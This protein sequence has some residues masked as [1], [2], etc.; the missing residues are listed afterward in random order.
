MLPKFVKNG[1]WH[2]P[3]L[4]QARG[5]ARLGDPKAIDPA[6]EKQLPDLVKA[7]W[8]RKFEPN[9]VQ[10]TTALRRYTWQDLKDRQKVLEKETELVGRMHAAGVGLLAGSD[11][12]SPLVLAGESIHDELELFVK[13]GLSPADALRTATL[14]PAKCLK[15]EKDLGAIEAGRYADLVLLERN[16]LADIRHTRTIEAVWV[17]GRRVPR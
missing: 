1:T 9:G 15:M 2:V 7:L 8:T 10:L 12:P 14:N 4:T 3:T 5:L 13:A 6:T 17:G 16:P 11:T